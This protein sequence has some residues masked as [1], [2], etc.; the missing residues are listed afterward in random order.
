MTLA[1]PISFR[2]FTTRVISGNI[3][4][5]EMLLNNADWD[6]F[7]F[8]ILVVIMKTYSRHRECAFSGVSC[9]YQVGG[10]ARRKLQSHTVPPCQSSVLQRLVCARMVSLLLTFETLSSACC[11]VL[12]SVSGPG[13]TWCVKSVSH[14]PEDE[15]NQNVSRRKNLV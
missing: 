12:Q 7:K 2:T 8:L 1:S 6:H 13:E 5:S 14:I 10:C 3:V 9:S 4:T 11:A 15:R